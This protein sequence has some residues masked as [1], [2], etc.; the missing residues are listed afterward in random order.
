MNTFH[1]TTFKNGLRLIT[2]PMQ[3]NQTATVMVLVAT[4]SD[5]ELESEK[6]LSHFLEHMS[7]KG[8][9]KR[10][11]SKDINY[12]LDT[13]GSDSNAFTGN[14]YTGYYAKAHARHVDTL[15]DVIS[16]IYLNSK[17]PED[18]L[19]KERGVIIEEINMY[20]DRPQSKV[21][22]IFDALLYGNQPAGSPVIGTKESVS[23]FTRQH[24]IDY[25]QKHYIA[26]KTIVIVAGNINREDVEKK[27]EELFKNIPA[28][29]APKK[30][31]NNIEQ[32]EARIALHKKQTDQTHFILG[33]KAFSRY[34]DRFWAGQL[35]AVLMG[36]GMSSR[37]FQK[38]REELGICYY[39][40]SGLGLGLDT[41]TFNIRAGVGNG[42]VEEA[43][44]GILN[45]LSN[46]FKNGIPEQELRKV[47]DLL[48]G[49][50]FLGLESS[51]SHAD[52]YGFQ[53]LYEEPIL[54][55]EEIVKK[56]EN[57][58]EA[59]LIAVAKDLFKPEHANLA[60]IGPHDDVLLGKLKSLI[61][62]PL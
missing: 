21:G 44:Q 56:Y 45:E 37:L 17:L 49:R 46:L 16:D 43:V 38:M 47:K 52:F 32:T 3:Q 50:M 13:L 5:Y 20:E 36:N 35:L 57:L 19:E 62:Q 53:E 34:D 1:K 42:R 22:E 31:Q 6:G 26:S 27:V 33:Y 28:V 55:P 41:G 59:D 39:I 9:P 23:S 18:E 40:S 10:P 7:F 11:T 14:E 61:S 60:L 12:E 25:K 29:E 24:F 48:I 8:T 4:G 2:V 51:D 15:I 54:S 30:Y 58:T